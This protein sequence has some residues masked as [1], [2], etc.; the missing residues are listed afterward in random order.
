MSLYNVWYG[1]TLLGIVN[2]KTWGEAN[3][4]A[5]EKWG[6]T[7]KG[8]VR[9]LTVGNSEAMNRADRRKWDRE[10]NSWD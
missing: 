9:S 1:N 5:R 7:P 8:Q 6:H 3:A 2:E 4:A 10:H